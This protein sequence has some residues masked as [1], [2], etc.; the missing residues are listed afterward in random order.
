M[1]DLSCLIETVRGVG[2]RFGDKSGLSLESSPGKGTAITI[3]F[4]KESA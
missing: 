4:M 3:E 2:Y 1:G